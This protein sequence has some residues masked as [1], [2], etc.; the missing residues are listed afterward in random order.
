MFVDFCMLQ[1]LMNKEIFP[2]SDEDY[3]HSAYSSQHTHHPKNTLQFT[4]LKQVNMG[5]ALDLQTFFWG[6]GGLFFLCKNMGSQN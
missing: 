5:N 3:E 2:G 1:P 4:N 6:V